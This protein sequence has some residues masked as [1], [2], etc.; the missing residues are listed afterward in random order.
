[1]FFPPAF[2]CWFLGSFLPA[3]ALLSLAFC[4]R[5]CIGR[6]PGFFFV[7][8]VVLLI[9]AA[10]LTSSA[11]SRVADLRSGGCRRID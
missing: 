3:V 2:C 8:L 1:M 9:V 6:A 4:V 5:S 10:G 7:V 11:V